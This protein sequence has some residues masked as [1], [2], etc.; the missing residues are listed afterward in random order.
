MKKVFLLVVFP[1]LVQAQTVNQCYDQAKKKSVFTDQPCEKLGLILRKQIDGSNMSRAD[2]L[3]R[4]NYVDQHGNFIA[5]RPVGW[6][7]NKPEPAKMAGVIGEPTK[8]DK[9]V[10]CTEI[11]RQIKIHDAAKSPQAAE[12][13]YQW[14]KNGCYLLGISS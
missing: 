6:Y 5:N 12:Y 14:N 8:A 10:L 1:V 9:V 7:E 11:R 4:T 13:R 3:P 2:G